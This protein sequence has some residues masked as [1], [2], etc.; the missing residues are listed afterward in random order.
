MQYDMNHERVSASNGCEIIIVYP[1]WKRLKLKHPPKSAETKKSV[2]SPKQ[3]C[4]PRQPFPGF[5]PD[6]R[7]RSHFL[8]AKCPGCPKSFPHRVKPLKEQVHL[9]GPQADASKFHHG[10]Q[11]GVESKRMT[12]VFVWCVVCFRMS[13][14]KLSKNS[15]ET[16]V[17]H[18][19]LSV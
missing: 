15:T 14:W 16:I 13:I 3:T 10:F 17:Y 4:F 7:P 12:V 11:R 8:F 5:G 9:L 19:I 2:N 1:K 6:P 18:S